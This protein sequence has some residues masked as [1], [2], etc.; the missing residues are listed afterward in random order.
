VQSVGDPASGLIAQPVRSLLSGW[1]ESPAAIGAF[2]AVMAL[3]WS[4]KPLL[5]LLSDFVPLLGSRRRSYLIIA[6]ASAAIGLGVLSLVPI[7][8]G[9]RWLLLMLLFVPTLGIAFTDVL[10]DGLMIEVG[11]PR[12]LTGRLQ[13][14]QW[15]AAYLALLCSGV[16]GGYLTANDRHEL[17]FLLC[18]VLWAGSLALALLFVREPRHTVSREELRD[19]AAALRGTM[20]VPGLVTI[21]AITFLWDF[22]PLWVSVNYLN[23]TVT[24]GLSE[25]T[26]GNSYSLFSAGAMLAS[27]GYALYCRRVG[28]GALLHASIVAGIAANALYWWVGSAASLYLVSA[29]AGFAYV[30]G[31]LILLDLAAR[32]VP[33]PVA[34]TVFALIMALAN[35]GS[36]LAEAAG[37]S[38][39]EVATM[40]YGATSAY[41][42]VIVASVLVIVSCWLW[43]PRLRHEVP[44][45]WR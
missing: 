29:L 17:A 15:F 22:N 44:D 38:L 13:S 36:S 26:Y 9:E 14:V 16:L 10:I 32:L 2:M 6:T 24:L 30:T 5:A 43:V 20:A 33:I 28:A 41:R 35:L 1:G 45:W 25:Q 34:A 23:I 40:N 4:L 27:V 12:G 19:T 21:C 37:G 3:P 11:K 18:A 7:P 31:S 42:V 39:F 8:P